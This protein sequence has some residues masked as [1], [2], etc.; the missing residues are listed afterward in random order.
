MSSAEETAMTIGSK[1]QGWYHQSGDTNTPSLDARNEVLHD[2][3]AKKLAPSGQ[4]L[5]KLS[6]IQWEVD[7]VIEMAK[8]RWSRH[9]VEVIH[10]MSF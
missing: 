2:I 6:K 9:L 10:N 4:T 1:C 7:E 5:A 3:R 8:T